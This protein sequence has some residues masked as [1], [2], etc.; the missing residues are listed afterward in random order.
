MQPPGRAGVC[1]WM[2]RRFAVSAWVLVSGGCVHRASMHGAVAAAPVVAPRPDTSAR[3]D[4]G[5]SAPSPWT[6]EVRVMAWTPDGPTEL[7][8]YP[9]GP[10]DAEVVIPPGSAWYV[11]PTRTLD[12]AAVRELVGIVRSEHVPGLSLRGQRIAAVAHELRDLPELRALLLDDTDLDDAAIGV[13]AGGIGG[14]I[15]RLSLQRT[16]ID[17]AGVKAIATTVGPTLLALDL[18]N[19]PVG[20]GGLR[21]LVTL[22]HLRSVALAGTR[23]TDAGGALLASLPELDVIDLGGTA[24]AARTVAALRR[25]HPRQVFLDHTHVGKEIATLAALAPTLVR[26][27]LSDLAE[28]RPADADVAWLAGAVNLVELGLSGSRITDAVAGTATRSPHL[29]VVRLADTK[30]TLATIAT[31]A[32]RIELR[33]VDLAHTPVDN[34]SAAGLLALP[35]LRSLRLDATWITDAAVAG[36]VGPELVELYLSETAVTDVGLALLDG[37]PALEAL[38]LG[39][40]QIGDVTLARILKLPALRIL[41]LSRTTATRPLL[42]ALGGLG[43]LERLY[44]DGTQADDTTV[45]ALARLEQLEVLHLTN[46]AVDDGAVPALRQLTGLTELAIG[47][48]KI[49]VAIT[50]LDA[51]PRLRILSLYGQD[52]DDAR[53][54]DFARHRS[55][56]TLDLSATDI[57]N[58]APL[59][60]LPNLRV[61]GLAQD[62]LSRA[63]VAAARALDHAGVQVFQ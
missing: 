6:V 21:Q 4:A 31:I 51:W 13:V 7:G 56:T 36:P 3:P 12:G 60:S 19:C 10:G 45:A 40:D 9:R 2:V 17:D 18:E 47:D 53:L 8:R 49:R 5:G 1:P 52:I 16:L 57:T 54:V 30:I 42:A 62:R 41:V 27:D 14:P 22:T 61:L 15:E 38:G 33:D 25:L 58:P 32:M 50:D 29:R 26:F 44:L 28:Y 39:K 20:D 48:T 34:A 35:H 55:L 11:E 23:V 59:A 24:V 37:I 46:T 63:G 43:T